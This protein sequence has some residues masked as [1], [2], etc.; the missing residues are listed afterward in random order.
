MP[1]ST[2]SQVLENDRKTRRSPSNSLDSRVRSVSRSPGGFRTRSEVSVTPARSRGLSRGPR[3]PSRSSRSRSSRRS[4]SRSSRRSRSRSVHRGRSRSRSHRRSRSR[5]HRHGRSRSSSRPRA[6]SLIPL[7]GHNHPSSGN[8]PTI[9][10]SCSRSLRDWM[11][12]GLSAAEA[13]ALRD[14]FTPAFE[15]SFRLECPQ[16]ESM[17]RSLKRLKASGFGGRA[18]GKDL[19]FHSLQSIGYCPSS[20]STLEP[21][22]SRRCRES[23]YR[24]C[25]SPLG[26]LPFRRSRRIGGRIF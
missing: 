9:P 2:S 19:A 16:L 17:K 26:L 10:R 5:S 24:I 4:R 21:G 25:S 11:M 14:V 3:S 13:R 22:A 7:R 20:C 8:I 18:C 15:G 1:N 12:N 23:I 6:P